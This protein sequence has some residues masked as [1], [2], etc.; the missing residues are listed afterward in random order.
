MASTHERKLAV[1][2]RPLSTGLRTAGAIARGLT[3][4]IAMTL[5]SAGVALA[6]STVSFDDYG[7][8]TVITNQYADLGGSGQG[9]VFGPLPGGA[10][11]GRRPVV[12]TPPTGQAQSGSQVAD[13]ATCSGCGPSFTPSTTGTFSIARS[14]VSVYVG[15]LGP[16]TACSAGDTAAM[17]CAVV[18]LL[19]FDAGGTR[20][21]ASAPALIGE[22]TGIH[23]R[24]VVTAPTAT[25]AAF[26]VTAR[27]ETDDNKQ[28]AI[29]DLT[30]D[31]PP[32]PAPPDFTLTPQSSSL[33]VVNGQGASD[34][35][36]IGRISNS[37]GDVQLSAGGLPPG[38]HAQFTPDPASSQSTLTL[39]A[40]PSAPPTSPANP[41]MTIA[42]TPQSA[43]AGSVPHSVTLSVR[44]ESV[45]ADVVTGANLVAALRSGCQDVH[46]DD[47]AQIDLSQFGDHPERFPGYDA[48]STSTGVIH[49]PDGVTLES[50]RSPTR[51]GG[52]LF[53]SHQVLQP[54]SDNRKSMLELGAG[55]SVT[56]LRLRGY[57]MDAQHA[58]H[59]IG[60]SIGEPDV[61]VS[62]DEI[63]LWPVAGVSVGSVPYAPD[64]GATDTEAWIL[65]EALRVHITN[66]FIHDNVDCDLG[67]GIVVGNS[68]YA[69][70]DRNVFDFNKHDIAG[71]G[72]SGSGYIAKLNFTLSDSFKTCA[73][74]YGGHFDMHGTGGGSSHVGGTAGTYIDIRDN[75]FRGDQR[76]HFLGHDRR[77]AFDLR[78]TPTDRA[79]FTGNVTE[80]PGDKAV[81]ISGAD[82]SDLA[83][84]RKLLVRGNSYS[85]NTS[86]ELT[87]GDFNGDGCSDVFLA[88]GTIWVYSPCGRR[89]WRFLNTSRLRLGRLAFGDFNGDGKTD[90]FSQQG[91][92]RW[93]VS[94][95]GTGPWTALPAGSNIPSSSYRFFDFNGDGKTDIFR[96]N[97]SRF[98]YSSAGAT[99][100]KPLAAS[101]LKVEQLRFC[102]FNGDGKA[103]VFSLANHQW[104]VSYGGRTSW[105]HL[106]DRLSSALGELVFG[107]F[108]G[109]GKCDVARAHHRSWQISYGGRAPWHYDSPNRNPGD[110]SGTL[111]GRFSGNVCTDV[112]R[113]GVDHDTV[114]LDQF[115]I[116]RCLTP[117]RAWSEQNML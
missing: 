28:I 78:G 91:G 84:Q 53:M 57:G 112:L 29:D 52:R 51:R 70:I 74:G 58:P 25:I 47:A 99:L 34:V 18:Q 12:R 64:R 72:S 63:S 37:T 20:I 83:A 67:Y 60:L 32:V 61:L 14:R 24:L 76:Y 88:T 80:A 16:L 23:T 116:S 11:D 44:V 110:F 90:V 106:N 69:L 85:V 21:A 105:K 97:G 1:V 10:G 117:F 22:G 2:T 39:T 107:D 33:T 15:Y 109:D 108:N 77:P 17:S 65:K 42:G 79:I 6:D 8:G 19:A 48:V 66:N 41:T 100:W 94:Y 27:A 115:K 9:V 95:S 4:A 73:G 103:D 40:D 98:Y 55:T 50:D 7:S 31:N 59:G 89:E 93:L 5:T 54:A 111:L 81:N 13:I 46:V 56:G 38:V 75:T 114:H 96:A 101:R 36:T 49:I 87:V 104:S 82:A 3:L 43:T 68:S 113:F 102:D 92:D 30:F 45:C 35:I 71:D 86:D 62:N 26:E